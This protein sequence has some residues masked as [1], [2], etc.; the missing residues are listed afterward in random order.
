MIA[1]EFAP[2]STLLGW[3]TLVSIFAAM[4]GATGGTV[5]KLVRFA[6][7]EAT[8]PLQLELNTMNGEMARLS[9]IEQ[10]VLNHQQVLNNGIGQRTERLETKQ[11]QFAIDLAE[12]RGLL[13]GWDGTERRVS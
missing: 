6:I 7:R 10:T 5:V 4:L 1:L 12:I 9:S 11:D 3:A 13:A 2:P 8:E